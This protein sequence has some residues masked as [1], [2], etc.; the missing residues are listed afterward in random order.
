MLGSA[1]IAIVVICGTA[2]ALKLVNTAH[3]RQRLTSKTS[4]G[5][6]KAHKMILLVCGTCVVVFAPTTVVE[7]PL[8]GDAMFSFYYFAVRNI[9]FG[10]HSSV[11]FLIYVAVSR[12]FYTTYRQIFCRV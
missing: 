2:I 6:R 11:N 3:R 1:N 7:T 4:V 10:I 12:K 5:D 9:L 8:M